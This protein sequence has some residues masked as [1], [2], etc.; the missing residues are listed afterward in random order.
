MKFIIPKSYLLIPVFLGMGAC[1]KY[2]DVNVTPNN[3]TSVTPAVL[4]PGAQAG[5][6]FANSNELNR[7]A[8]VLVQQLTGAANNPANYDVYQTN[9]A[10]FGNQWSGELYNGAL[11]NYQKLIELG[12]ATNSK[13]YSGIAKIMKAYTFS[14]ATDVWG[15]VPYSQALQGE[16][17][18]TPRIDKQEDIYKGNASLGIQSLFDLVREG[19]KDLDAASVTKPGADDLIYGGDLAKWKRAGNTLLLKF[20]MTISRK[21]PALATSVINEVITG[22]NFINAN[23]VDANV[24]FGASVNSQAPIYVYTNLSTFKD[25]LI[26]STRYLNLLT[27]LNDPRLPIFFTKPGAN[28]VTL[29]NGFRGTLPT[30][31]ANWSRYNKYVTG[32]SGE[33]PVRLITN[34]QR[35]FILAE[36]ALRLGTPGDPQ[37]L[38]KEGITASMTLA[39]LTADQIAAYFTANPTVATLAGTTEEKI[40]QVITQK[41]IAFTGNGLE[42][43]NDYRR[44]GYPVLQ[45]SQNAAG[46]DGTRPVRAVYINNEIQRNPNFTNPAPQSNVR[47]WWDID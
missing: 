2:L 18:T 47:V 36:A 10:D 26:L 5:S 8:S 7:F 19:I 29:D 45:P 28:Y 27:A 6:A 46:I 24:T 1:S 40:A 39:G 42:S 16:A 44:T 35:A 13:A 25:D 12:D 15:D 31:V 34:F 14:I 22:N 32:N 4:L 11:V 43:W 41:Y 17:F 3:P 33:G 21:E 9:G 38:Y 30:P 37:A 23:N 20:A